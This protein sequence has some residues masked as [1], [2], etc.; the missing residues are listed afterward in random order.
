[1]HQEM[2][3]DLMLEQQEIAVD[4]RREG[5][6]RDH[7]DGLLKRLTTIDDVLGERV[8]GTHDDLYDYWEH[9]ADEGGN[10][11]LTMGVDDIP[12]SW[13]R[14]RRRYAQK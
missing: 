12:R 6:S 11:D 9:I 2:Y 7:R 5:L 1:M 3:E 13:L 4:L 14:K 8:A 10:P